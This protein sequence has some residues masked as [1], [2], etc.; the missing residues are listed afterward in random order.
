MAQ[1]ALEKE[2][3]RLVR[4]VH[5]LVKLYMRQKNQL[6]ALKEENKMLRAELADTESAQETWEK[7]QNVRII[8]VQSFY[9]TKN[10]TTKKTS[11]QDTSSALRALESYISCLD[12][13][14]SYLSRS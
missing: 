10:Q 11:G 14:I 3:L 8:G 9:H 13:C 4:E 5:M 12:R 2:C 6:A 1:D 7:K